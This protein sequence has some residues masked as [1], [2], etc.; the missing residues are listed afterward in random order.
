ME[1]QV[2]FTHPHK[3]Y[4]S[5]LLSILVQPD[6]VRLV[7]AYINAEARWQGLVRSSTFSVVGELKRRMV[8]V[9]I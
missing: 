2:L 9:N 4:S 7:L 8:V 1:I 5:H 6:Y 3:S